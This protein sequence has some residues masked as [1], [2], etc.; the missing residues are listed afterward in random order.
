[1]VVHAL[2]AAYNALLAEA[3]AGGFTEP[4]N[5]WTASMI[6]AHIATNDGLITA[7]T[8]AVAQGHAPPYDNAP[9]IN[10]AGLREYADRLGWDGLLA[11]VRRTA[12]ALMA[13]A[14]AMTDEQGQRL[15]S[16][17]IVDGATTVVDDVVPWTRMLIAHAQHHLPQYTR[18]LAA[19][20]G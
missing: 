13:A 6:L 5:G 9:S 14:T 10:D 1:M 18:Q 20:R 16:S 17:R 19:L 11:E 7:V 3:T 2:G 12:D 15:V 8:R 4:A